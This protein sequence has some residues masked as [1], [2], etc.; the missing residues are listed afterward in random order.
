M[1]FLKLS[2]IATICLGLLSCSGIEFQSVEPATSISGSDDCFFDERKQELR[3]PNYRGSSLP[4][5]PISDAEC[6]SDG[7]SVVVEEESF[8]S[9]QEWNE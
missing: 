5:I 2:F 3:S 8:E 6:V 4:H 7:G 9:P 1:T